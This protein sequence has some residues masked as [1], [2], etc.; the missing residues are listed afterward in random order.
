MNSS[1]DTAMAEKPLIPGLFQIAAYA[2]FPEAMPVHGNSLASARMSLS[3][4]LLNP[5]K[6]EAVLKA[7]AR[8][9][10]TGARRAATDRPGKRSR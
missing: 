6:L 10:R 8:R 2:D 9:E 3:D 5:K 7:I 1:L 4:V